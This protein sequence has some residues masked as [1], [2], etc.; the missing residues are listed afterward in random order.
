MVGGAARVAFC[1]ALLALTC[2][3]VSAAQSKVRLSA[4]RAEDRGSLVA[5]ELQTT[6]PAEFNV[7]RFALGDWIFVWSPQLETPKGEQDLNVDTSDI[8]GLLTGAALSRDGKRNGVRIYVDQ[9]ADKRNVVILPTENGARIS[10]P[11]LKEGVG[12]PLKGGSKLTAPKT[13]KKGSAKSVKTSDL[14][15]GA[16]T[17][18]YQLNP[19]IPP[20]GA[21]TEQHGDDAAEE[22]EDGNATGARTAEDA[23]RPVGGT[24]SGVT[25]EQDRPRP[26]KPTAPKGPGSISTPTGGSDEG[27]QPPAEISFGGGIGM[28]QNGK[29][30]LRNVRIELFEI[31]DTPLDQALQLLV[32]PTPFNIIVD[33]SVGENSV[34]LS[35]KDSTTDLRS[36][37]DMLTQVY[38]LDYVVQ[39]GTIVVA[40]KDKING[41]L[42]QFVSRLFVLS[43]ADPRTV[44]DML[45]TTGIVT[46]NQIE[47]Y[48]GEMEYPTVND[49]TQL[50]DTEGGGDDE[51]KPIE[52]NVSSTPRNAILVRGTPEQ[53]DRVASSIQMLDRKPK[54]IRLEVRVCEANETAMKNIGVQ[55]DTEFTQTFSEIG[56]EDPDDDDIFFEANQLGSFNRDGGFSF[57]ATLNAEIEDGNINV[58]AQPVLTTTEG[59]QAIFFAGERLPYISQPAVNQG[60]NFQAPTVSYI[61]VGVI[62][63]FKPRLDRDGLITIDVNPTVSSL[64]EFLDLGSG[65]TAP[66]TQSRQLATTIRVQDGQSFSLSGMINNVERTTTTKV[67]LLGDIPLIGPL[68]RS[69]NKD[70]ERTEIIVLVTP[71]IVEN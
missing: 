13:I 46:E 4:I 30:E 50:S 6:G 9:S 18:D 31:V 26:T 38:G 55:T 59:K 60:T 22:A 51:I 10:I 20:P 45:V 29:E 5:I 58:L 67:P 11:R 44:R 33:A 42:I 68:F 41:Q 40:A 35:F 65:A 23:A 1:A 71:H 54:Q 7:D 64:I 27:F 57:S 3:C 69:K 39:A 32:A 63:N 43:Y 53:L 12:D 2:L 8:D 21:P 15:G 36:A 52:T 19:V 70:N 16:G 24:D 61:R 28:A 48:A 34:S 47:Y 62:L 17:L 37:L 66:R 49:S 14:Q 56:L 25:L